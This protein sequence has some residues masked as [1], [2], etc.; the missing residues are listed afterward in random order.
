[1][2]KGKRQPLAAAFI[3]YKIAIVS[4]LLFLKNHLPSAMHRR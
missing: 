4:R 1:M 3:F 2:R